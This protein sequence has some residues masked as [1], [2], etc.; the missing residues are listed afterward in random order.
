MVIT[1]AR[2]Y[3]SESLDPKVKHYSRANIVQAQLKV[4]TVDSHAYPLLPDHR[5]IISE[6]GVS[7]FFIVRD[8][9]LR[10]S[11]DRSILQGISRKVPLELAQHL[12]I[13]VVEDDLQ[14][15]DA[16]TAD[17]AFLTMSSYQLLPVSTIDNRQ[18]GD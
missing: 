13:E 3:S 9:T 14:P 6:N 18:I 5:G 15:Y 12:E 1:G 10:T 4:T 11:R 8:G 7:N 17:E 16:Y 2:S